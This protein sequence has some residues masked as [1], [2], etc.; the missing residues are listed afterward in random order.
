MSK[1]EKF[2]KLLKSIQ[3]IDDILEERFGPLSN[4]N[5]FVDANLLYA[6]DI[7]VADFLVSEDRK[8]HRRARRY[9]RQ[10]GDRIFFVADAVQ[11]LRITFQSKPTLVRNIRE[12]SADTIRRDDPILEGMEQ[13]YPDFNSWWLKCVRD[14]RHCW[15]VES[16]DRTIAGL[17]VRKDENGNDTDA[18]QKV[19][20]IL[21]ICTFKVH[22]ENRGLKIGELLLKQVL[23]FAQRNS[24]DLVYLTTFEHQASL[25]DLVEYYGF[26]YTANKDGEERIYE[27][28]LSQNPIILDK[29]SSVF[30]I[31]RKN[32]PKFATQS[33]VKGFIVPIQ[34]GYH[35]ILY[36]DLQYE[37]PL[38]SG[39]NTLSNIRRPGNTIRKVYLCR[40]SSNL[41]PP[42]SLL[43]FYK[44]QSKHPPSQA[45]TVIGILEEVTL[46]YSTEQL[47]RLTGGRSVYGERELQHW[48]ATT[49]NSVKVINYLLAA[50]L[51]PPIGLDQ[52]R[53]C[54]V[55]S[56]YPPQS[57]KQIYRRSLDVLLSKLELGFKT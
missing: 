41:E 36:P 12:V 33:P 10:L 9:S 23:W 21:K 3:S 8:L 53:D 1:L 48:G 55:F 51:D 28:Q 24:Y 43:F 46:A 49:K 50:Y 15:I 6:L 31:D 39:H 26:E 2:E 27:K 17:I 57:I 22:Q 40:A 44:G 47:Y 14:R 13:D 18:M 32:Y 35:D 45:V 34:E 7:G 11:H 38:F 16:Q 37:L 5:D 29:A 4:A 52:L 56:K 54:G 19:G 20:K 25:I 30:E 42:G